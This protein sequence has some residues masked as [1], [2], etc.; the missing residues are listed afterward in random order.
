MFC[1][2]VCLTNKNIYVNSSRV[3][4]GETPVSQAL[5]SECINA[6]LVESRKQEMGY[7]KHAITALGQALAATNCDR[8]NQVYEIVKVILSKVSGNSSLLLR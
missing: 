1:F 6:L 5:A 7:K 8:F 4:D 2:Y 3:K